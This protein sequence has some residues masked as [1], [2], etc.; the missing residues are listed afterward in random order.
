MRRERASPLPHFLSGAVGFHGVVGTSFLHFSRSHTFETAV[1]FVSI[2]P[3]NA[4]ELG[5]HERVAVT[6]L[7]IGHRAI[8]DVSGT[9]HVYRHC[10]PSFT[11]YHYYY[12]AIKGVKRNGTVS[13]LCGV[14]T[15]SPFLCEGF[16]YRF[17]YTNPL[18]VATEHRWVLRRRGTR[19]SHDR[20]ATD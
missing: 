20:R 15:V 16:Y 5:S 2:V 12:P 17:N 14:I 1:H 9:A 18:H 19:C 8:V 4:G 7:R 3:E 10:I 13:K 11:G 6:T